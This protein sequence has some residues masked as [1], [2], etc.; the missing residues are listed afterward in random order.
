MSMMSEVF[1]DIQE[2]LEAGCSRGYIAGELIR[3]YP[4]LDS[5]QSLRMILDVEQNLERTACS[6]GE[7]ENFDSELAHA[8]F[9]GE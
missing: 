5:K 9:T 1:I 3:N 8:L 2:M 6:E 7:S 4:G